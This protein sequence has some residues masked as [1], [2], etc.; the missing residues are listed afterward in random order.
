M[1]LREYA[2]AQQRA[3]E[4]TKG[5]PQGNAP[6][7][8]HY[9]AIYNAVIAYH[10]RHIPFPRS[11]E[12]W[13][14]AATDIA[15][16]ANT[17]ENTPFALDLLTA[18]YKEFERQYKAQKPAESNNSSAAIEAAESPTGAENDPQAD[19]QTGKHSFTEAG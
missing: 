10:Q 15:S 6:T 16:I 11:D 12:E 18:V 5:Q 3:E 13:E 14:A 9:R 4:N 2:A 17:M 1:G 7:T 19:N 8:F